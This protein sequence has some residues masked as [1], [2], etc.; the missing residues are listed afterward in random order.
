MAEFNNDLCNEK[1]KTLDSILQGHEQNIKELQAASIKLTTIV[2]I[3]SDPERN[4]PFWETPT[5]QKVI[6]CMMIAG[7]AVLGVALGVNLLEYFK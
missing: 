5:G 2:E 1:H 7:L 6:W 3:L 4:K